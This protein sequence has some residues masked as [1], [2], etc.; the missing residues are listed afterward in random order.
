M[1]GTLPPPP[2]VQQI[3]HAASVCTHSCLSD[4]EAQLGMMKYFPTTFSL[5]ELTDTSHPLQTAPPD[6]P[7][8][9]HKFVF[10]ER[11]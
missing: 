9:V 10:Y 2:P 1:W 4:A 3:M 7:P 6:A 5:L 8:G 11:Q